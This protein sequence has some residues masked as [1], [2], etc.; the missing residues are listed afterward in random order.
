MTATDKLSDKAIRAALKRATD[1]GKTEAVPDGAGLRLD[2]QPSGAGWWRLRYR[3][4][5]KAGML[6]MGTYPDVPLTLARQRR[7]E[8]RALVAAGIDPSKARK[9]GKVASAVKAGA[10][11]LA[12]AGLP[13]AGSFESVA[14]EWLALVHEPAVSALYAMRSRKQLEGDVFPLLG[15]APAGS[16]TAPKV[17]EVLRKVAQRGAA[18]TAQRVKQTIGLVMRYAIATGHA[19]RD[20]TP[21]LRG[22]LPTPTTKHYPAILEPQ[23][24]GELL[25]AVAGYEGQPGTRAALRLAALTFQRPG[26]VRAMQWG[27]IDLEAAA[28]TL[29]AAEM[30]R[31]KQDKLTGADHVVPLAA[32]AVAIL[33]DLHPLTGA[34]VYCFPGLRSA[35]RPISDVTMNAAMRRLGFPADEMTAHGFRAMARTVMR[36]QLPGIDPEWIE[37]QLAHGKTGPLGAAYDRAQYLA[38][39]RTMMQTWADYLDRLRDGAQV[40]PLQQRAG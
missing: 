36:E 10:L 1:T 31:T 33:R 16:V 7:D 39:R 38:Q 12:D 35:A 34:G 26:N 30:K 9:A 15:S 29:P 22:A 4:A 6:S 28:W 17:L 8:A 24:V 20:P 19:D 13:A 32:Q 18:H 23:R 3:F 27:H 40:I 14:R 25:R 2:C 5:G 37:A 21:D 11:A